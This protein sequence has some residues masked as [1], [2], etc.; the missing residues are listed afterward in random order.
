MKRTVND[1]PPKEISPEA[2]AAMKK[3]VELFSDPAIRLT[4]IFAAA[5]KDRMRSMYS[6]ILFSMNKTV[7]TNNGSGAFM[8]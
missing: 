2:D 5:P 7:N 4:P 3:L 6:S 8:S 1:P